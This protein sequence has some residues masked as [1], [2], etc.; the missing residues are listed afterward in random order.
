MPASGRRIENQLAFIMTLK[1]GRIASERRIYDF[2][3]ML[4]QLGV[5]KAKT[6]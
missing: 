4:M 1:D 5:L 3:R 2:T 6:A